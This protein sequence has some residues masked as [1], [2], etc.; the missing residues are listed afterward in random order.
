MP[1]SPIS[2]TPPGGPYNM[3]YSSAQIINSIV[4]IYYNLSIII[5][6]DDTFTADWISYFSG[7][8]NGEN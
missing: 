4:D 8:Q 6:S 5:F 3:K 7:S 1:F 2:P